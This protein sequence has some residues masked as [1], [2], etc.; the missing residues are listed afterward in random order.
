ME[1]SANLLRNWQQFLRIDAYKTKL[2]QEE[3]ITA[4]PSKSLE[5]SSKPTVGHYSGSSVL[6]TPIRG[7]SDLAPCD[8]EEANTRNILHIADVVRVGI[9]NICFEQ[10]T[11]MM[12]YWLQQQQ[13]D[14]V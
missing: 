11:L 7:I 4:A 9:R 6:C 2:F 5:T 1:L 13:L 10:W 12:R 8:H 3:L 14:L